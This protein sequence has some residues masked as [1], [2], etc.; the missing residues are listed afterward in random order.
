MCV[1]MTI[2]ALTP[3]VLSLQQEKE[4]FKKKLKQKN[5]KEKKNENFGFLLVK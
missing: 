1:K 4:P 2:L 3:P 5:L